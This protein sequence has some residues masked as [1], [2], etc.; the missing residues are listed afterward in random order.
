MYSL[1]QY[2]QNLF[3]RPVGFVKETATTPNIRFGVV[4]T[5]GTNID[6][7]NTIVQ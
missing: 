2:K 5:D 4:G 1:I 7:C 3:F 6:I